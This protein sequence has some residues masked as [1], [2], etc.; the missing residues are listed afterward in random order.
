MARCPST[1]GTLW[2]SISTF[3]MFFVTIS[4]VHESQSADLAWKWP[5]HVW[6]AQAVC[7]STHPSL[8]IETQLLAVVVF[9]SLLLP[10]ETSKEGFD[11][12]LSTSWLLKCTW[13]LQARLKEIWTCATIE[14]IHAPPAYNS[15]LLLGLQTTYA[16]YDQIGTTP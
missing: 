13:C 16:V 3:K 2:N 8:S 15:R 11:F 14:H 10:S 12:Q 1:C 6:L 9:W 5:I 4:L 7:P